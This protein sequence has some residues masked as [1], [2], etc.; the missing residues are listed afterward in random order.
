MTRDAIKFQGPSGVAKQYKCTQRSMCEDDK[1]RFDQKNEE[2]FAVYYDY[3]DTDK[4]QVLGEDLFGEVG[5]ADRYKTRLH[6]VV[7]R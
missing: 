4:F 6:Y 7:Q 2:K 3:K 5:D 1:R